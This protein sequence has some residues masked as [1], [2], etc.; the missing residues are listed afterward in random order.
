MP[1]ALFFLAF[2]DILILSVVIVQL[3]ICIKLYDCFAALPVFRCL[4]LLQS[5]RL[6]VPGAGRT[7]VL[8]EEAQS[9]QLC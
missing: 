2:P 9:G 7:G 8:R 3:F 1:V 6:L 4:L 5:G